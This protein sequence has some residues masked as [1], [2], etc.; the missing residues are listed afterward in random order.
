VVMSLEIGVVQTIR[1]ITNP[2][3]LAHLGTIAD[4]RA[5]LRRGGTPEL[6]HTKEALAGLAESFLRDFP[7]GEFPY[8]ME[9]VRQH[10]A[11][12]PH[13]QRLRVRARPDPRRLERMGYR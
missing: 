1:G 6:A 3:K 12:G 2:D 11:D 9:H 10:V 7:V 13:A 5:I 4:L 8:L